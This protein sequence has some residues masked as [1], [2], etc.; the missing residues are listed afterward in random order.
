MLFLRMT[1][2]PQDQRKYLLAKS[3]T[4]KNTLVRSCPLRPYVS[5]TPTLSALVLVVTEKEPAS[6][7]KELS[8]SP[9]KPKDFTP[10]RSEN[11]ESFDVWYFRASPS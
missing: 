2:L 3:M 7:H 10:A 8:A 9:R 11:V 1:N 4:L 6:S 5:R